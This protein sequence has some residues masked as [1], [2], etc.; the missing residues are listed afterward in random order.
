M[1]DVVAWL[2]EFEENIDNEAFLKDRVNLPCWIHL[3]EARLDRLLAM[4]DKKTGRIGVAKQGWP[5]VVE[6]FSGTV[7][8][9][10]LFAILNLGLNDHAYSEAVLDLV[11][12]LISRPAQRVYVEPLLEETLFMLKCT[13]SPKLAILEYY[14][15]YKW[16]IDRGLV[17]WKDV[18]K[19]YNDFLLEFQ[20]SVYDI[21]RESE[22]V[23]ATKAMLNDEEFVE[24]CCAKLSEEEFNRLKDIF[25]IPSTENKVMAVM[26]ICRWLSAPV[27]QRN[28]LKGNLIPI[29]TPPSD[30]LVP[31]FGRIAFS[32]EDA[33]IRLLLSKRYD[34][35][36]KVAALL[37]TV[38][39]HLNPSNE[40][41][42]DRH[43]IPIRL[44]PIPVAVD[45]YQQD[46]CF[47]LAYDHVFM[48]YGF[49]PFNHKEICFLIN[50]NSTDV[51]VIEVLKNL[52]EGNILVRVLGE[53]PKASVFNVIVKPFPELMKELRRIVFVPHLLDHL[54]ITNSNL[55]NS[56]LGFDVET[57]EITIVDAAHIGS[58]AIDAA[59]WMASA[60]GMNGKLLLLARNSQ[61]ID[62]V[63]VNLNRSLRIP[64]F[65]IVRWDLDP[66]LYLEKVMLARAKLLS[67]LGKQDPSLGISCAA[68]MNHIRLHHKER[69]DLIRML[70][71]LRPL[72]YIE[73]TQK[74][75]ECLKRSAKIV[76]CLIDSLHTLGRHDYHTVVVLDTNT[77]D[78]IDILA[79]LNSANPKE[80]RIYGNGPCACRLRKLPESVV[81]HDTCTKYEPKSPGIQHFLCYD[82]DVQITS[83]GIAS[84]LYNW[85]CSTS[86][87][88]CE[89]AV[90][91]GFVLTMLGYDS[92]M[93]VCDE[94]LL[95]IL[96]HIVKLRGSWCSD[97]L[98]TD[99]ITT[100][101]RFLAQGRNEDAVVSIGDHDAKLAAGFA[102]R[103][104][105]RCSISC[106]RN[107]EPCFI[108]LGERK[109][110]DISS[111]RNLFPLRTSEELLALCYSMQVQKMNEE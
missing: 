31:R 36:N 20:K 24:K 47:S 33:A 29:A 17:E 80:L 79:I 21:S 70:E 28:N 13:E 22:F 35:G 68:A 69:T 16:T 39:N 60:N 72:E 15:S 50:T 88:A 67:D 27:D 71:V 12:E 103:V 96:T 54:S 99:K 92:L 91:A 3:S 74:R 108:A 106:T 43:A 1:A 48:N 56:F 18:Q 10:S 38:R 32:L 101:Q 93:I 11:L 73:D 59:E 44:N 111:A 40:T 61:E 105:W 85:A 95:E 6:N 78:D 37:E 53:M 41:R 7:R 90:A 84:P 104:F 83:P 102:I 30:V 75:M 26:A 46:T 5:R 58:Y 107:T 66:N 82:T 49:T 42:Y 4:I 34:I 77:I 86:D 110:D 98:I 2:H 65:E 64:L 25:G 8:A 94:N 100:I 87:L 97:L 55:I 57:K 63:L 9:D 51:A 76:C 109:G 23:T 19:E 52:S 45:E 62:K 14:L 81:H 89:V